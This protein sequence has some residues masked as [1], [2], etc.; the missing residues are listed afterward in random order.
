MLFTCIVLYGVGIGC[1]G[2][3]DFTAQYHTWHLNNLSD[4]D[5]LREIFHDMKHR[6]VSLRQ[7]M[8]SCSLLI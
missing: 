6:A 4:I 1:G 5:R 8:A 2:S 7:L 3:D